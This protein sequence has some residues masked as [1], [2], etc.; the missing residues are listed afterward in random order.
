MF[1]MWMIQQ[2]FISLIITVISGG[3]LTAVLWFALRKKLLFDDDLMIQNQLHKG[4][5]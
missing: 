4:A 2:I 1:E 5:N 3:F